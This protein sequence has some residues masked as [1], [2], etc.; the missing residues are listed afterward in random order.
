MAKIK[1]AADFKDFLR[2]C[3]QN[4]VRFMVI[5]SYAVI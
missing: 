4:E 5:G 2:L 3:L 1:L